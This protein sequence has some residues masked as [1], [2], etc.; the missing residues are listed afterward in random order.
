[1]IYQRSPLRN[2]SLC[3]TVKS[4]SFSCWSICMVGLPAKTRQKSSLSVDAIAPW[5]DF[6]FTVFASDSTLWATVKGRENNETLKIE[7]KTNKSTSF[8][9]SNEFGVLV[10]MVFLELP[11]RVANNNNNNNKRLSIEWQTLFLSVLRL[12]CVHDNLKQ[13][14]INKSFKSTNKTRSWE[15]CH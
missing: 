8:L 9:N 14:H 15:G 10:A 7:G 4:V 1:M 2:G 6:P 11:W 3:I 12:N 5:Y 13:V